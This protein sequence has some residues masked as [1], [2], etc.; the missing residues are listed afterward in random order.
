LETDSDISIIEN[1]IR[2]L[3][4]KLGLKLFKETYDIIQDNVF[5]I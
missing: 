4:E 5:L 3:E 2:E 1:L